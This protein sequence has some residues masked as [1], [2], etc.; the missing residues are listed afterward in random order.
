MEK[1]IILGTS[2]HIDHGTTALV[3]SLTGVD[4]DR[5]K[6]EKRRGITIE[7][8]FTSLLLPSG[9]R[10]GIVDMPGHE[11]F[12]DHMVAGASGIDLVL[13][14][15]A[16]DEGVMPQTVEHLDICRFLGIDKGLVALTK[17]DLVDDEMITMATDDVTELIQGTF[18]EGSP[19][20]PFSSVSGE[21]KDAL[22]R[23]MDRILE[24]SSPKTSEGVTRM[25]ID[26]VFTM[27]GFGTVVTGTLLSGKLRVGE[28]VD[29]LPS[30]QQ[31]KIRGLQVYNQS[32]KEA[33]AGSRTAVNLQGIEKSLI[34]RG[35]ILAEPGCFQPSHRVYAS[36]RYLPQSNRPLPDRFRLTFHWG[37]A[38]SFGRIHFLSGAET[39]EPGN[40]EL[41]QIQLEKPFFPVFGD[42][43]ISRDF[44]TNQTL[45]GGVIL[46][47]HS[48]KFKKKQRETLLP[49]LQRLRKQAPE[50]RILYFLWKR[51]SRGGTVKE[52]AVWT[53]LGVPAVDRICR[54]LAGRD[55]VVEVDPESRTFLRT[56]V[57]GHLEET[58]L[59]QLRSFHQE[60][61]YQAGIKKEVLANRLEEPPL[62]SLL[63]FAL[64]R[65]SD[66]G[67]IILERDGIRQAT[68]RVRLSE[69]DQARSEQI[70][71]I[72][73][74]KG[75]MPPTVKELGSEVGLKE[76]SLRSLLGY[77]EGQ[78]HVIK[79]TDTLFF[80]SGVVEDLK[81]RLLLYLEEH[82]EVD[83]GA[84]KTLSQTTRKYT[85]P[86]LEY[87]DR[88]RLTLRLG[89]CRVLR[90]RR[91]EEGLKESDT[92]E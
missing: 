63:T 14:V 89:D 49:W 60:V 37:T 92:G 25:P 91:V 66:R 44:S 32:V 59:E 47:A 31:A 40:E 80:P 86:L 58:I 61:P 75:V 90:E 29:I 5:L 42:R 33:T 36:F 38:R 54:D 13:L 11:K 23:E 16:A 22:V 26:R 4:T 85:I 21:G 2:G 18:L 69:K 76:E 65:L 53:Q 67:S 83:A 7:L 41:V 12:V 45:G 71:K 20:V 74:E 43:W 51:K 78:G 39:L 19:I 81:Q 72:L 9:Q 84:F 3:K 15:V 8:G 10:L 50:D 73:E 1:R 56:E 68:H 87:F 30:G 62:D 46:D 70:Q 28:R 88:I 57:L 48:R 6:E 77:M 27:K 35:E 64:N 24:H 52:M 17:V 55:E 34:Q 82:G 79:V